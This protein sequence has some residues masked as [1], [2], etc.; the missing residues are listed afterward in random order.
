MHGDQGWCALV[1]RA[2]R[3]GEISIP[4]THRTTSFVLVCVYAITSYRLGQHVM[5]NKYSASC[6]DSVPT[7]SLL[8]Q[9]WRSG[10]RGHARG[11]A[12]I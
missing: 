5:S 1:G 9:L 4:R 12:Q 7:V 2:A 10:G 8:Q 3:G 6:S 11:T